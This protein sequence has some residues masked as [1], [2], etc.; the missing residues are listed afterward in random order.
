MQG[1]LLSEAMVELFFIIVCLSCALF[2]HFSMLVKFQTN[3]TRENW[4]QHGDHI[5]S[6]KPQIKLN[7]IHIFFRS[8]VFRYLC[9]QIVSDASNF[10]L[11]RL[12]ELLGHWG[13]QLWWVYG[14]QGDT[15]MTQKQ[16]VW[17]RITSASDV[18][19]HCHHQRSCIFFQAGVNFCK[20]TYF[21]RT[22]YRP[23]QN[24]QV[25]GMYICKPENSAS[26]SKLPLGYIWI[27]KDCPHHRYYHTHGYRHCHSY[28]LRC[29]SVQSPSP[30]LSSGGTRGRMSVHDW[31]WHRG[32]FR[33]EVYRSVFVTS[34]MWLSSYKTSQELR[35]LPV[36]SYLESQV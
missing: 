29:I 2:C 30:S 9:I 23:N 16:I 32:C 15:I 10:E 25:W 5:W 8:L 35:K 36:T 27:G 6:E 17:L 3:F 11:W 22:F 33:V 18:S 28:H 24:W 12:P 1:R 21:W 34:S 4:Q 14:D 31:H 20:F 26:V 7:L 13:N 19:H